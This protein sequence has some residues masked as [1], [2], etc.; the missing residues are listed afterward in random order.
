MKPGCKTNK[1]RDHCCLY[2][3]TCVGSDNPDTASLDDD[4]FALVAMRQNTEDMQKFLSR[5]IKKESLQV[6]KNAN[7]QK[8]AYWAWG[9]GPTAKNLET[10][11]KEL[12]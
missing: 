3:G 8:V 9:I 4:G 11:K 5:W 12:V 1:A 6:A 10:I 7:L 2:L